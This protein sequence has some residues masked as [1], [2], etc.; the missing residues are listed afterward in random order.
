MENETRLVKQI[1][2]DENGFYEV[3]LPPGTYSIFVEDLGKEYCNPQNLGERG[4]LCQI[5]IGT[6]LKEYNIGINHVA[7]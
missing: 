4:E 7:F 1:K 3:E 2:S 5:T 6:E